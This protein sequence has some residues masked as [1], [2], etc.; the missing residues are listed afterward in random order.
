MWDNTVYLDQGTEGAC[1]GFAWAHDLAGQP[2]A[3]EGITYRHALVIYNE[4]KKID[5][6]A[7]EEYEGTSVLAGAKV[8]R[9]NGWIQEYRWAFEF[10]D[11][12][13]TLSYYG[14]IV[15]G[16]PWY[17]GM[18]YPD[19]DGNIK[20]SGSIVG[21]HAILATGIDVANRKVRLHNSWGPT[22]GDNGNAYISWDD[23]GTLLK[24]EGEACVPVK[25]LAPGTI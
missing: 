23:L 22:W 3:M 8:C 24:Q 9:F 2:R 10:A 19:K 6:W 20:V 16:I 14:P 5:E 7:G 17:E 15:L 13:K 18:M 4:A 1:V 25:P 11:V 12:L 21:G